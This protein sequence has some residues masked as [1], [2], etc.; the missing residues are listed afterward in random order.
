MT[1]RR[2]GGTVAAVLLIAAGLAAVVRAV[3]AAPLTRLAAVLA[4]AIL[5]SVAAGCLRARAWAL[6]AGFFVGLLW[7]W[8]VMALTLQRRISTAET[9]LWLAWAFGLIVT[10][11]RTRRDA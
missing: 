7:A 1:S 3:N 11:V 8:A 6:G 5:G 2:A 9:A 4:A 10:T